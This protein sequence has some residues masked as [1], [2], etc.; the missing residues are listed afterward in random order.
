MKDEIFFEFD[1]LQ[2]ILRFGH[3]KLT[4]T[5]FLLLNV[6]DVAAARQ[7]LSAAP[8]TRAV[9]AQPQPETALQIAFSVEGLRA[10]EMKESII[11]GFSDEFISGMSG[12]E[13]RSRRLG[14]VGSNA[15][16]H[17]DWGGEP[18]RAPHVL[19]LLYA[20][21]GGIEFWKK[22]V[23]DPLFSKAF[24]QLHILPT[25]DIGSI[26]PFGFAD[27]LSQ[28]AID[29]QYLQSTDLHERDSFS[30]WVAP[31]EFVL[32]YPNEYGLYTSR[33]LIDPRIDRL[34]AR[35]PNAAEDPSFK[36]LGRNGSY[37]V[38]RQLHQDV[39]GFW[40]F[41]D[42][43]TGS[44]PEKREQ[45]AARMVGRQRSGSP[46]APLAAR[47]IPGILQKDR[48]NHFTYELDPRGYRCPLGAHLRRVNPRT[49]DFPTRVTGLVSRLLKTFGFGLKRPDEDLIASTRFHRLL[50]RGRPYGPLLSPE[51]AVKPDAP[52][53]ER[54][55]QFISLGASISRQ[56]EFVQNAWSMSSTFGGVQ[57]ERD[58]LIG[59]RQPL[60]HGEAT[61]FFNQTDPKGPMQKTCCLP[62]FV[63]VRGGGYFFM[64]GLRALQYIAAAPMT[65]GD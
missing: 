49:G 45:L 31:G 25:D 46:L 28:P 43:M 47:D 64:P 26:E 22:T 54:G 65:E 4:D 5:C 20:G 61:D 56:F 59:I 48:D 15:P 38:I 42:R 11:K 6:A 60:R 27:G 23:M 1:D 37:L 58:P 24:R 52:A 35:L 41:V 9:T 62:Q 13:S 3:G 50:R 30:N 53:A 7:W 14:D 21:K 16:E 18:G 44:D 19:L 57:Q 10:L 39:P 8:V 2:A 51:D 63:T 29:W 33:P 40:Q 36:D 12:D 55:L 17:W 34:A 32:G